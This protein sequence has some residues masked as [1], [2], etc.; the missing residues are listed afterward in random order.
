MSYGYD[1][2]NFMEYLGYQK[3]N[4]NDL[5]EWSVDELGN[6]IRDYYTYI[7]PNYDENNQNYE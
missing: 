6:I 2:E 1:K 5:T 4:G 7:D 3:E